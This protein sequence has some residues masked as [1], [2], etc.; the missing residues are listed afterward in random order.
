MYCSYIYHTWILWKY[1]NNVNMFSYGFFSTFMMIT[2]ISASSTPGPLLKTTL[3]PIWQLTTPFPKALNKLGERYGAYGKR[4]TLQELMPKTHRVLSRAQGLLVEEMGWEVAGSCKR[5]VFPYVALPM[6]VI[7]NCCHSEE[8]RVF[9]HLYNIY[10]CLGQFS[11]KMIFFW[12]IRIFLEDSGPHLFS[13]NQ[14]DGE[15]WGNTPH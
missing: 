10:I 2:I 5:G 7:R 14:D 11:K 3:L 6:L 4:V 9:F 15:T 12:K 13:K 8:H 1:V